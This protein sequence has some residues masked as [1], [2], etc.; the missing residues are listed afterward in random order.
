VCSRL[1]FQN[2]HRPSNRTLL[3]ATESIHGSR[4]GYREYGHYVDLEAALKAAIGKLESQF[5][6]PMDIE[7]RWYSSESRCSRGMEKES[8]VMQ[9]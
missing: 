4:L 3:S 5:A 6:L 7:V 1:I 9:D 2:R 8:S